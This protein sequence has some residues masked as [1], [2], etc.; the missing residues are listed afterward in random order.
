M[1]RAPHISTAESSWP[2]VY[3]GPGC[4]FPGTWNQTPHISTAESSGPKVYGGAKS[5]EKWPADF[6]AGRDFFVIF[7]DFRP[8][9]IHF[10]RVQNTA[11]ASKKKVTGMANVLRGPNR[12]PTAQ[13]FAPCHFCFATRRIEISI[14]RV[15]SQ[16]SRK[17]YTGS[18]AATLL[19]PRLSS[20]WRE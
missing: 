16:I 13:N 12:L 20:G 19:S 11:H 6:N 17:R 15:V 10:W 5:G 2:K 14:F 18:A 8:E 4:R 7:H 1:Q 9:G 3:G